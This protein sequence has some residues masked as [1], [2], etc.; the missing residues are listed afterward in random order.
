MLSKENSNKKS[1]QNI[2]EFLHIENKRKLFKPKGKLIKG[3]S[4][5]NLN[6]SEI[7]EPMHSSLNCEKI[8]IDELKSEKKSR[9]LTPSLEAT[10]SKQHPPFNPPIKAAPTLQDPL[11]PVKSL[12]ILKRLI[13]DN[14]KFYSESLNLSEKK[15]KISA[16]H[17]K[18]LQKR[19]KSYSR[20]E[21]ILENLKTRSKALKKSEKTKNLDFFP[22]A[23]WEISPEPYN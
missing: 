7:T 20:V 21:K 14:S 5:T 3:T 10:K 8:C 11:K 4:K 9:N 12:R 23:G 15:E 17:K 1:L 19:E 18:I 6:R 2:L 13:H 22:L 16:H